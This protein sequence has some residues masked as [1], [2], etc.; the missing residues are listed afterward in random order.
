MDARLTMPSLFLFLALPCS[1]A[2]TIPSP[3]PSPANTPANT[4]AF[5]STGSLTRPDDAKPLP[6]E[7]VLESDEG[8]IRSYVNASEGESARNSGSGGQ[9]TDTTAG[10]WDGIRKLFQRALPFLAIGTALL[11]S[12]GLCCCCYCA[13]RR[14]NR[15]KQSPYHGGPP[16]GFMFAAGGGPYPPCHS[17]AAPP[18]P[19]GYPQ[20]WPVRDN[21]SW[22]DQGPPMQAVA[23]SPVKFPHDYDSTYRQ[24][25]PHDVSV[26]HDDHYAC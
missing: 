17:G 24:S 4:P 21:R 12:C 22:P 19:Q 16:P 9:S 11:C 18:Y 5:S 23:G 25:R 15:K 6:S 7:P 3:P 10:E 1:A 2:S 26:P 20:Q 13:W 14:A 8:S